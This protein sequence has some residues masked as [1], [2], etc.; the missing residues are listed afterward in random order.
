VGLVTISR[1][2]WAKPISDAHARTWCTQLEAGDILY[3][4][5]TPVR[6]R[7]EDIAFLLGQQQTD[8][9]L[10]KNIAYKPNIDKLS[11]VDTKTADAAAVARLH[12]IM[13]AYSKHV[14]DFLSGFLAPDERS[15]FGRPVGVA[16]GPDGSL[17]VADDVGNV[18]WR[19]TGA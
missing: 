10:H 2:E 8:S 18:I 9:S 17:L 4:P 6:L 5:E 1:D 14:V 19:V 13:R 11:G 15:S 7:R 16:L 3:F 12:E